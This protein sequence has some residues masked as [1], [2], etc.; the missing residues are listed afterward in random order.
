[1]DK[2]SALLL[3]GSVLFAALMGY[4]IQRGA[5]C[6]VAAVEEVMSSRRAHRL[7]SLAEAALWV[8]LGVLIL[9]Q[10]GFLTRLPMGHEAGWRT[11]LGGALL[12]GG[13]FV[14]RAC[15][16]G[17]IARWSNGDWAYVATPIGFF[18]GCWL[19]LQVLVSMPAP[20]TPVM[21]PALGLPWW[22]LALLAMLLVGRVGWGVVKAWRSVSGGTVTQ[23]AHGLMS[24]VWRPAPA[25]LVIG[26]SFLAMMLLA[27]PW[28]YTEVLSDWAAG[29]AHD[30]WVRALLA[31]AL[32]AGAALGGWRAGRWSWRQGT[33]VK[34]PALLR[35]LLGGVLM[36]MGSLLIP[37]GND[38]L[39]LVGMPLLWPY[40][41]LAFATMCVTIAGLMARQKLTA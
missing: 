35:C 14:N 4:A 39:I 13:A 1:M 31:T 2:F 7:V 16:F 5:T 3:M 23:C 33:R 19:F 32:F 41:W 18:L 22:G 34:A 26:L 9:R 21:A 6:T 38:G 28:A 11:V 27:G 25:T 10:A 30:T 17:A 12:G 36:G 15:V 8:G 29:M 40:A 20:V 24:A 37:G